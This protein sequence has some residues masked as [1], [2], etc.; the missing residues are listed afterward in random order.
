MFKVKLVDAFFVV[1]YFPRGA[2]P[3]MLMLAANVIIVSACYHVDIGI[4]T[5]GRIGDD[6]LFLKRSVSHA[7]SHARG[8]MRIVSYVHHLRTRKI[9]FK[10]LEVVAH[11]LAVATTPL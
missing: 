1:H 8:L 11:L 5:L 2:T 9:V 3:R 7:E 6:T 4:A 10:G